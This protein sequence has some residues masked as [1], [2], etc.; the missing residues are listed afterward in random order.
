MPDSMALRRTGLAWNSRN[1]FRPLLH[2]NV[3]TP[4]NTK[5]P[6]SSSGSTV[7]VFVMVVDWSARWSSR[8][9]ADAMLVAATFFRPLPADSKRFGDL[10]RALR[11]LP[12]EPPFG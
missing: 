2:V 1:S 5:T 6:N 8:T 10:W 12:F 4:R 7:V 11:T 3:A 9:T